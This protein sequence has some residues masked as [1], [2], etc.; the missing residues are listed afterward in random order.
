MFTRLHCLPI[1]SDGAPYGALRDGNHQRIHAAEGTL[2][3][4]RRHVT[5]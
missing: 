2:G 5:P 4:T 1:T 3:V